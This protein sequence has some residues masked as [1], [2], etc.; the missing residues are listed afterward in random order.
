M[1]A[2]ERAYAFARVSSA[3]GTLLRREALFAVRGTTDAIGSARAAEAI[4]IGTAAQRFARLLGRYRL[5]LRAYG[6]DRGIFLALLRRHEIENLKLVWRAQVRSLPL[7]RWWLLWRD[8]EELTSL[9]ASA[10]R[11]AASLHEL[12]DAIRDTPYASIARAVLAAHGD[13]LG[14]AELA[15]DR[16]A[17]AEVAREATRLPRSESLARELLYSI[18]RARDAEIAM[19]GAMYGLSAAA[20]R[21]ARVL[22]PPKREPDVARLCRRAFRGE[23][24][25]LAP[26]IAFLIRAEEERGAATAVVERR[27]DANLDEAADRLLPAE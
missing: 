12:V 4:G 5:V 10:V 20:V 8:F 27:G 11:G 26:P 17:S 16:W 23:T 9:P 22:P 21:A 13:D 6:R 7:E 24:F 15:F 18:V 25:H 19:R 1:S 3:K 2:G 14:S